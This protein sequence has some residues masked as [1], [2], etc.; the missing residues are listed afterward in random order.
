[1]NIVISFDDIKTLN[2]FPSPA[3]LNF[4][5]EMQANI[6]RTDILKRIL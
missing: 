1:M 5:I 2:L 6:T 4:F 3:A